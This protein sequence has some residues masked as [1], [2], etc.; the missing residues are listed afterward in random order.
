MIDKA[1]LRFKVQ[2][3]LAVIE[4][5]QKQ[6]LVWLLTKF[7]EFFETGVMT[8]VDL[9]LVHAMRN[10]INLEQLIEIYTKEDKEQ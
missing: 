7:T 8:N 5:E 2:Q 1:L 9:R 4:E 10:G 3:E 6:D